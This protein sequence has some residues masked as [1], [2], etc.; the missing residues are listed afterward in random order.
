MIR[1]ADLMKRPATEG[2]TIELEITAGPAG[3]ASSDW[4]YW[5]DLKLQ[6]SP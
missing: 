2:N 4:T 5:A 3:V 6:T 1:F